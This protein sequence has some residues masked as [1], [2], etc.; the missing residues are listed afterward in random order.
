M[1]RRVHDLTPSALPA[2]PWPCRSCL[3]WESASGSRGI[4]RAGA[5]AGEQG[6]EAWWQAAQLEWGTL[7]KGVWIGSDLVGFATFGPPGEFPGGRRMGSAASDDAF[8][9][10]TLWVHPD[11]RGAGVG[12]LLLQTVL[13]E[14]HR[15]GRRAVEAYCSR[16]PTDCMA[17]EAFLLGNGFRVLKDHGVHPLLRVDLRQTAKETV[18]AAIEGVLAALSRRERVPAPSAQPIGHRSPTG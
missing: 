9:L 8:L 2:L 1:A 14:A 15:H 16:V 7:G 11:H 18:G 17:P 3:F 4:P 10:A 12:S 5:A 6:K 13:R